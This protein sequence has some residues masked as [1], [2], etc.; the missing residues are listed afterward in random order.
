MSI[1][2]G[3]M[4]K[5]FI[6]ADVGVEV[7][8]AVQLTVHRTSVHVDRFVSA[9][10]PGT[11]SVADASAVGRW[12]GGVLA[13][14]RFDRLPLVL[15][16]ARG[17]VG[18]KRLELPPCAP[19]ELPSMVALRMAGQLPFDAGSAVI[20]YAVH[21]D[22][23]SGHDKVV[24]IAAGI[25]EAVVTRHRE[26]AAASGYRLARIAL[27]PLA[28]AALCSDR[29]RAIESGGALL[30]VDVRDDGS[31]EVV[32]EYGSGMRFA[33]G[34]DLGIVDEAERADRDRLVRRIAIEVQRSWMSYR[35]TDDSPDVARVV[36]LGDSRLAAGVAQQVRTTLERETEVLTSRSVVE[37]DT[38]DLGACWPLVGVG[39]QYL[40][41]RDWIDFAHPKRAPDL[42][43]RR[44]QRWLGAAGVVIVAS[45]IAWQVGHAR[46]AR[47][48]DELDA[49]ERAVNELK[50]QRVEVVRDRLRLEHV[51]RWEAARMDSVSHLEHILTQLPDPK[52]LIIGSLAFSQESDGIRWD[53]RGN[54]W[55]QGAEAMATAVIQF[56]GVA[57]DRQVADG[58][59]AQ[60]L[61]DAVY[62]LVTP[63][64]SDGPSPNETYDEKFGL[65][66]TTATGTAETS[67]GEEKEQ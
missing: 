51:R 64:G 27:R 23:S 34:V 10:I 28:T 18:L 43:A 5:R 65:R 57:T 15:V 44:R 42:A 52:E 60:L 67:T 17:A 3:P 50:P 7:L 62:L 41:G 26:I 59:R 35:V 22:G 8:S 37:G 30:A 47:L 46:L 33:R 31:V 19:D 40:E 54:K 61:K 66:L 53:R 36:V 48:Q 29:A 39:I 58:L 4:L 12:V 11:V 24:V 63:I 13:E 16:A 45:A 9:P 49:I 21:G 56:S 20:D 38:S 25:P 1:R 14:G 32:V 2:H 55:L 6:V